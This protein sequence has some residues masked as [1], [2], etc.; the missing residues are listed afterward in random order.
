MDDQLGRLLSRSNATLIPLSRALT[1]V[2]DPAAQSLLD[3]CRSWEDYGGRVHESINVYADLFA[4]KG[5]TR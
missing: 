2:G 5:P 4:R 1:L 3:S